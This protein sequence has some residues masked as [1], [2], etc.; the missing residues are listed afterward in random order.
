MVR[1]V[2]AKSSGVATVAAVLL[3]AS[4]G[5]ASPVNE[6]YQQLEALN[7]AICFNQW[8]QAV[9]ITSTLIGSPAISTD[10]RHRLVEFRRDLQGLSEMRAMMPDNASCDRIYPRTLAVPVP[11]DATEEPAPIDWGAAIAS[12]TSQR[13]PIVQLDDRTEAEVNPAIPPELLADLPFALASATAIDTTDGFNVVAGQ[14][15]TGH[16]TFGFLAGLGDR[17]TLDLDVTRVLSGTFET[18]DDSQLFI[19]DRSGR[20]LAHNDDADGRQS[21]IADFVIPKTD[22]YFAVVT[23]H[24]NDPLLGDDQTLVGWE[25]DGEASFAYTLTLTGATPSAALL[26]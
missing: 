18:S 6:V 16:E 4:V 7:T 8:E 12:I 26:R 10:Y 23:S 1:G 11:A 17:I 21:L 22:I 25:E 9:A 13:G 2:F 14:V 5:Q 3:S 15:S 24:N 19:F 20:L